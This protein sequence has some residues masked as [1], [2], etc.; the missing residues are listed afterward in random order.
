MCDVLINKVEKTRI[1]YAII[2]LE[3]GLEYNDNTAIR[4]GIDVLKVTIN[5]R[6]KLKS[7]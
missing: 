1:E 5:P 7:L 2:R 4:A 3:E 6:Q